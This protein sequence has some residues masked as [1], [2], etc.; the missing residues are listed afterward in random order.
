MGVLTEQDQGTNS[1]AC[2]RKPGYGMHSVDDEVDCVGSPGLLR[3]MWS[4]EEG[5]AMHFCGSV[6]SGKV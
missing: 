3:G 1:F 4:L 6:P 5:A 2:F